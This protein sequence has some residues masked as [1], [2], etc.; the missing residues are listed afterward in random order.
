MEVPEMKTT[1]GFMG[2]GIEVVKNLKDGEMRQGM[3]E[4]KASPASYQALDQLSRKNTTGEMGNH[5]S[6]DGATQTC[7]G[8]ATGV[9]CGVMYGGVP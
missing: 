5:I 4:Q 9:R 1:T 6:N 7:E 8:S 3:T 2:P